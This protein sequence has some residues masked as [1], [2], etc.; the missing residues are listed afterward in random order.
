MLFCPKCGARNRTTYNFCRRCGTKIK[1]S[2]ED[3]KPTQKKSLE[4]KINDFITL[5]LENGK[6]VIYVKDE[7]FLQCKYLLIEIPKDS[8][9]DFDEFMSIDD[10]SEKLDHSLESNIDINQLTPEIEF[11]GHCSNLQTWS[12]N[13]YD[14]SLLHSNLAFPLLKKL[15]DVGDPLAKRVFKDEIGERLANPYT[16]V[17]YYLIQENYLEYFNREEIKLLMEILFEQIEDRFK[18]KHSSNL[19]IVEIET[20]LSIIKTN[21]I[22]SNI[23]LINPLK[24]VDKINK[25]THLGFIF[26]QYKVISLCLNRCGLITLPFSI[27][28]FKNLEE[29]Y[30]TEN[31]LNSLP[32]SIGNLTNLKLLNLSDNHLIRLPD[33]IGNLSNLK[34]LHLNHNILQI[35][36]ETIH[37]LSKLEI[38]SIWG[39][40][41]KTLPKCMH[42]LESLKVLGLSFNQLE[43]FPELKSGFEN[44]EVL[45]L[46]NNKI[47]ILPE[48]INNLKALKAL[49]LNNNPIITI[50]ESLL[51]LHSLTDL[52]LV[53]TPLTSKKTIEINHILNL[54][55][56][57]DINI[58]K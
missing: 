35:L 29:L 25:E 15:T 39:N 22:S 28:N 2:I 9:E 7:K 49:W 53:N 51:D 33:E 34:E 19:D 31:R 56:D 30:L 58:W 38:I 10:V 41:L 18:K 6:T 16:N 36:P 54:L 32:E 24:S 1:F 3:I 13:L 55:E 48:N 40:Q 47:K 37:K 11:W 50:S 45:D 12:E 23:F 57:K 46:S 8:L 17:A 14:T 52:Y 26:E 42:Q 27:G 44:L 4:F 43:E 21:L 5:K 20:L